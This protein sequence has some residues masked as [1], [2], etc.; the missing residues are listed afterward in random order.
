M[1]SG[2]QEV[3]T[4]YNYFGSTAQAIC[5][6]PVAVL[7]SI[8]NGD[9]VIWQGPITR[10][11]AMDVDGKT[12]L[13]TSIG[14]IRFYWGTLTQARDS[15]LEGLFL[16]Q[17][18]GAATVPMPAFLGVCYAVLDDVSFGGQVSPPTLQYVLSRFTD[19]LVLT[20][21]ELDGDCVLPEALYDFLTNALY[22][23]GVAADQLDMQSF[24][25]AS[26]TVI[27]ED[28]GMSPNLDSLT[29]MREILGKLLAYIDGVLLY[30]NGKIRIVLT[31]L[32]DMGIAPILTAADFTDEPKPRNRGFTA[33]N[34]F[35]R[36]TFTDR[37]NKWEDGVEPYDNPANAEIQGTSV[38]KQVNYPY[39][40]RRAVAK[41]I[42]KRIGL[43]LSKPPFFIDVRLKP[44]H[45]TLRPGDVVKVT[46]PKL[47]LVE[48]P[49]RIMEITRGSPND[50]DVEASLMIEQTRDDSHDY[51]PPSDSFITPGTIDG[52]GTGTFAITPVTTRVAILPT[53]LKAGSSDGFLVVFDRPDPVLRM[54]KLH[55]TWNPTEKTYAQISTAGA[56]PLH[57]FVL[58]WWRMSLT[59]WVLRVRFPVHHDFLE[60]AAIAP[61]VPE[62]YF[63]TGQREVKTVG[64]TQDFHTI[65]P[66][67]GRK[68]ESGYFQA[69]DADTYDIEVTAA[70]FSTDDFLVETLA[71]IGHVPTQNVYFGQIEKFMIYPTDA[72]YFERNAANAPV[73]PQ[74][75]I[76]PDTDLKRYFKVTVSNQANEQPLAD[77][78]ETTFDRNDTTMSSTGTYTPDWGPRALSMYEAVDALLAEGF[79]AATA[80]S[81]GYPDFD[82]IDVALGA[83]YDGTET[84]DQ[85]MLG[86]PIDDVLGTLFLLQNNVY[87]SNP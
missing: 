40:T 41:R 86:V 2:S 23:M 69:V 58:G 31:R 79:N 39:I 82:D 80:V 24:I 13:T 9:L 29:S 30:E 65:D 62:F 15:I 84:A 78:I 55:W 57:G 20:A 60:F 35:I 21:H 7:D 63:V 36:L 81:A 18:G 76:S 27:G 5:M 54:A 49:C 8:Q 43:K 19:N 12:I 42:A 71:G 17:G 26:E 1:G 56:F 67:W 64:A 52:S 53:A 34:N 50:P 47:S 73:N 14:R 59:S 6:G 85:L 25:D 44:S 28:L 70:E 22:G 68:V 46:W 10:A 51:V 16:D 66:I 32:E 75:G 77:A 48:S 37:S 45:K 33:T 74:T 72:I 87:S 38:D 3:T 83:I 11:A 4:G 61:T